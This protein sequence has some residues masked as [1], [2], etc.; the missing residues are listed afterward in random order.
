MAFH[1]IAV[2]IKD[3]D[4]THRFYTEAMGFALVK[5]V[6]AKTPEGGW[7]RHLFYDTGSGMIAFWD[8]HDETIG[9]AWPEGLAKGVGLPAWTNHIAFDAPDL[10]HLAECRRRWLAAGHD[11]AEV[12]HGWCTSIYTMDPG[13]TMVE[14]CTTTRGLTAADRV[15][16]ERLLREPCPSPEPPPATRWHR[17]R[18]YRPGA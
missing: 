5:T 1:H 11:V 8:I 15:E 18:D 14:W 10:D 17:A 2:A 12:D 3:P 9:S 6:V 7:A 4:A 13:G 16:A